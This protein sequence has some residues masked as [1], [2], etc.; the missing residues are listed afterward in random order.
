[1]YF[2]LIGPQI[3]ISWGSALAIVGLLTL[4]LLLVS[5]DVVTCLRTW[6][7]KSNCLLIDKKILFH[8]ICGFMILIYS[9]AHTIGHLTGSMITASHA[10]LDDV[11]WYFMRKKFDKQYSY[12]YLLFFSIPG[13]TGW[14]LWIFMILITVT[15]FWC[16]W[17]W[18]FQ[19]FSFCHLISV[20]SI[21]ILLIVHGSD[22]WFN[23]GFPLGLL[24]IPLASAIMIFHYSR[25]ISDSF[26]RKFI[27]AD[28]SI[29]VEKDFVMMYI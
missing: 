9:L 4:M 10:D 20:P 1:M 7:C 23:W 18:C 3:L 22:S 21:L 13:S 25:M 26:C 2:K 8:Q 19:L 24:A 17:K 11:N 12:S 6:C 28:A 15:S 29:T 5:Y 14:L 16:V 27:V